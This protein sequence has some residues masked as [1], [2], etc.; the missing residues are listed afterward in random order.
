MLLEINDYKLNQ[1]VKN[2]LGN[3]LTFFG[4]LRGEWKGRLWKQKGKN[5]R[6]K[7]GSTVRKKSFL[8][9]FFFYYTKL[10]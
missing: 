8:K 3:L 1:E 5:W 6:R 7:Y 9:S 2:K 4:S 10:F